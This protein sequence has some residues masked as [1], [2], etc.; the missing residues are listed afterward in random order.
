M[1]KKWRFVTTAV[2]TVCNNT[3]LQNKENNTINE[4]LPSAM[5]L[6][7]TK[8]THFTAFA[9]QFLTSLWITRLE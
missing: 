7:W 2:E 9:T 4:I 5:V 8:N 3:E 1:T 6:F